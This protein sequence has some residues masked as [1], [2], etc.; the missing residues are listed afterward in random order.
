MQ[1]RRTLSSRVLIPIADLA[2]WGL[3]LTFANLARRG[4]DTGLVR[5]RGILVISLT[6]IAIQ[7]IYGVLS[8]LYRGRWRFVSFEE[9][10][11]LGLGTVLNVSVLAFVATISE[12]LNL[13]P[14][15][16]IFSAAAYQL[17][18]ALGVRYVVRSIDEVRRISRHD[19]DHRALVYGAGEA[20]YQAA[21]AL[22]EDP[23][24]EY[25]PVGFLDDD[26]ARSRLL[27]LGLPVLGGRARTQEAAASTRADTFV[28]AV[29]GI[30]R[31][32]VAAL[33]RAAQDA[34][35]AVRI[36]PGVS[37]MLSGAVRLGDIRE[38]TLSDLLG[39]GEVKTDLA[40]ISGYLRGRSVLVTG[41]GGSIGSQLCR[42]VARHGPARV[43]MLDHDETALQA[44]QLAI[45]GRGLLDS[46]D[47]VL[48]DIRDAAEIREVMERIRPDVVFHAA[49]HKHLTLLE[50]HPRE[51]FKTNVVGTAIVLEAAV[52]AGVDRF[53]NVSTDKAADAT[54]ALGVSKRIAEMLTAG[55][56]A[57]TGRDYISVRF[58]NVLG[59]R[60]SVVPTFRRQIRSGGPI[61]ITHPDVTRF[62]MT[63]EEAVQLVVQAGAIGRHGQVLVLDMGEPVRIADVAR[64]LVA[65]EAPGEDIPIEFTGLRP[66]EKLHETLAGVGE[67][68]TGRPHEL[69]VSY[70][71]P[72]LDPAGIRDDLD[73]S[74]EW[75]RA[76]VAGEQPV[77]TPG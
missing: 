13:V 26:P 75:M 2:L 16:T 46:P 25:L 77:W 72:A 9:T 37:A 18:G 67:H 55:V 24:S 43:V 73:G 39:R 11:V 35:L 28:I 45:D 50:R 19:R 62:F 8:G 48:A 54:S 70:D 68:A 14:L 42:E 65:L 61:T 56:A 36:L 57:R 22:R 74:M 33:S 63:I 29:P 41:A 17:L 27:V 20:G 59:S 6:A 32:E 51:A 15:S 69:I 21:K 31:D 66:G 53:V 58:G 49:A 44:L 1:L 38:L 60:G 34:G 23:A 10:G 47:L 4:F 71:V 5:W 7:I 30:G 64:Q 12:G 3:A 76:V 52:A 40:A